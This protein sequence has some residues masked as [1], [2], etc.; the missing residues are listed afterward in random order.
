MLYPKSRG[1]PAKNLKQI[2]CS[3]RVD[4]IRTAT[5]P[6]IRHIMGGVEERG[7]GGVEEMD[8]GR[9][10]EGGWMECCPE[11]KGAK[12]WRFRTIAGRKMDFGEA[13]DE[14]LW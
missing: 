1:T 3:E 7:F 4:R 6:V 5:T 8:S 10:G 14:G 12:E 13:L 11:E 2:V 9:C